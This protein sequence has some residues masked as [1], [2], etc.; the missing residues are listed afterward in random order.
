MPAVAYRESAGNF[1]VFDVQSTD[2][3]ES[4]SL[5]FC[6][7]QSAGEFCC[8]LLQR[9]TERVHAGTAVRPSDVDRRAR[10]RWRCSSGRP[11]ATAWLCSA[12]GGGNLARVVAVL[13]KQLVPQIKEVIAV[14]S[15][16][17]SACPESVP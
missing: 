15:G 8:N 2:A 11:S 6:V 7:L 13:I 1:V 3:E 14:E 5:A 9:G 10:T 16:R 12:V 17:N 4:R